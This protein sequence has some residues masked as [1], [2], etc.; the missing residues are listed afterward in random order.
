MDEETPDELGGAEKYRFVAVV[1]LGAVVLPF[2]GNV[3][4]IEADETGV[5]NGDTV[6][7]PLLIEVNS[8]GRRCAGWVVLLANATNILVW[9]RDWNVFGYRARRE[10]VTSKEIKSGAISA[11]ETHPTKSCSSRCLCVPIAAL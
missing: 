11:G 5:G 10:L 9:V 4:F 3:V 8:P 7:A 1:L 2:E 6:S